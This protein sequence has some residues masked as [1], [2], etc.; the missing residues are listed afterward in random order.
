MKVLHVTPTWW[1]ATRYGGTIVSVRALC[2]ALALSGTDVS[3]ATT[4]VDGPGASAVPL[5]N[6]WTDQGVEINSFA[7]RWGR[8]TYF[9]LPM[10][11][12]LRTQASRFDILHTHSVFLWPTWEA[13]RCA[14]LAHRPYVV[15]PRGMLVPELI[16]AKST[17]AKTV[18]L[19]WFERSNL[20]HA[21]AIH[22]TSEVERVD[23][24]RSNLG[25]L[26]PIVVIPNGVDVPEVD[27]T[28]RKPAQLLFV[29]RLSW[30]KGIDRLI[31]SMAMLPEITLVIAGPDNEGL[32]SRLQ[33]QAARLGLHQR[34]RFLGEV[35]IA[36][37][38]RLLS[39]SALL[40]LPSLSENFGNSVAEAMAVACPV[41]VFEGVGAGEHVRVARAGLVVTPGVEPLAQ[42]IRWMMDHRDEA[43][44]MGINGRRYV[45]ERMSWAAIAARTQSLYRSVLDKT[46]QHES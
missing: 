45:A 25:A 39:E 41:V 42:A 34:V 8:R 37:R 33:E 22:V 7:S 20:S 14:R 10:R 43:L 13:A 3:V 2:A 31:E 44:Q 40:V 30:K 36:E 9:S 23:L 24:L 16:R 21:A 18:W 11:R 38:D 28:V 27:F 19:R 26:P 29:G 35:D 6:A 1:P 15:T 46:L 17:L 4:N 5:D 12:F 32:Q